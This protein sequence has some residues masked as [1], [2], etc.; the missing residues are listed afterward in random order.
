MKKYLLT[1]IVAASAVLHA[2][3]SDLASQLE[4][5]WKA[6]SEKTLIAARQ[7]NREL[8][9]LQVAILESLVFEFQKDKM[10]FHGSQQPNQE[11]VSCKIKTV[12]EN[13]KTLVLNSEEKEIKAKFTNGNLELREGPEEDW[14]ILSPITKEEFKIE[15]PRQKIED[16]EGKVF[17]A[18]PGED[19]DIAVTLAYKVHGDFSIRTRKFPGGFSMKLEFGTGKDGKMPGKIHLRVPDTKKSFIVGTFEAKVK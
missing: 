1:L 17:T 2:P 12:D 11:Y 5:Y 16:L 4:G 15:F 3:A 6:D 9:P 8:D 7:A 10:T 13:A 19:T 14:L 18:E